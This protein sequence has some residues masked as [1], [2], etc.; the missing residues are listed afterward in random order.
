MKL[1][2][3]CYALYYWTDSA[4]LRSGALIE[5]PNGNIKLTENKHVN[6]FYLRLS[7]PL[8]DVNTSFAGLWVIL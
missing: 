8:L 2:L 7:F 4:L 5:V 1:F 6:M 3:S